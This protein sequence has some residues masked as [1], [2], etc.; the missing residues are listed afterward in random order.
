MFMSN[1][2]CNSKKS[3]MGNFNDH[4]KYDYI[5][6]IKEDIRIL[7]RKIDHITEM[8]NNINLKVNSVDQ[9]KEKFE[10]DIK[11]LEDEI[12]KLK[13]EALFARSI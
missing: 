4:P 12:S 13:L 7:S 1:K 11:K 10:Q 2:Y 9:W 5:S 3:K 8:S 6:D